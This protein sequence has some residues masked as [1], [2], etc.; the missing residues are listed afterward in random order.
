MAI[1]RYLIML[2]L[3]LLTAYPATARKNTSKKNVEAIVFI[4]SAIPAQSRLVRDISR[5]L[6]FSQQLQKK[7]TVTFIDIH[8]AGEIFNGPAH[9]LQDNN[10]VWTEKYRPS[11]IPALICIKNGKAMYKKIEKPWEIRRCL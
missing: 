3:L 8:R 6:Y 7:I 4:D 1:K 10:G 2:F 5:Q 9:Y 11:E